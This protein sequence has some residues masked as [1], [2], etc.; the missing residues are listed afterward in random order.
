MPA[1]GQVPQFMHGAV[2]DFIDLYFFVCNIADIAIT[3]AAVVI[4]LLTLK[5]TSIDGREE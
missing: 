5:G 3:G 4:A 2:V 1:N